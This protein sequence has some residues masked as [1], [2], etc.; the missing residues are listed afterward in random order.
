MLDKPMHE[1]D[2]DPRQHRAPRNAPATAQ[3]LEAAASFAGDPV[4]HVRLAGL[5]K[6]YSAWIMFPRARWSP[7]LAALAFL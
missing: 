1:T 4:A 5:L 3:L 7:R 6:L 2:I